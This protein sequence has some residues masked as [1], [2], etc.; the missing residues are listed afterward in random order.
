MTDFDY[1]C[2]RKKSIA[3]SAAKRKCGSKSKKCS[4]PSDNMTT[5]EWNERCG[6]VVSYQIGKPMIWDEFQKL[7]NDLKEQYLNTL[8]EKYSVNA[9]SLADMFGV[10]PATVLRV[11]K[12]EGLAV[13]FSKGKH[14]TGAKGEAYKKFLAGDT[15]QE[16]SVEQ[17]PEAVES[18]ESAAVDDGNYPKEV[19]QEVVANSAAGT[20]L[21]SFTLNF[22]G[23]V[24]VDMIANSLRYIL[25]TGGKAKIQIHCELE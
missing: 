9:R 20:K 22:S 25:A 11:V 24:N 13:R 10:N 8:I 12:K 4:L 7:P 18:E 15:T 19:Q 23:D 3:H 17:I 2:Y 6:D 21:D 16:E 1:D 14:P 5:K